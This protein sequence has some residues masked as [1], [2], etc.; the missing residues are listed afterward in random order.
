MGISL[1]RGVGERTRNINEIEGELSSHQSW[2]LC[3]LVD[4]YSSTFSPLPTRKGCFAWP[5]LLQLFIC[6]EKINLRKQIGMRQGKRSKARE[7]SVFFFV[8][9]PWGKWPTYFCSGL[10][11]SPAPLLKECHSAREAAVA[12]SLITFSPLVAAAEMKTKLLSLQILA[13]NS[14]SLRILTPSPILLPEQRDSSDVKTYYFPFT[15][16]EA[17]LLMMGLK[18]DRWLY[19]NATV[20]LGRSESR[21]GVGLSRL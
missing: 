4:M 3:F 2:F 21:R 8:W 12:V 7:A 18:I 19:L 16:M 5:S 1:V 9:L 6:A 14:A 15:N 13:Q 17:L 11:K 10:S 20:I